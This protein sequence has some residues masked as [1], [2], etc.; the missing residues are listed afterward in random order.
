VGSNAYL[1]EP[2]SWLNDFSDT[3]HEEDPFP[4][5][6]KSSRPAAD[7]TLDFT[8]WDESLTKTDPV[9]TP[10][11]DISPLLFMA[12]AGA[13]TPSAQ[14]YQSNC[15]AAA[16]LPHQHAPVPGHQGSNFLL[17]KDVRGPA[18]HNNG[19]NSSGFLQVPTAP[20]MG[21]RNNVCSPALQPSYN[22]WGVPQQPATSNDNIAI[23][24][25]LT[26]DTLAPSSNYGR[27]HSKQ[28][29]PDC[30]VPPGKMMMDPMCFPGAHDMSMAT[31]FMP[32][33]HQQYGHHQ[34]PYLHQ[35]SCERS[36][37]S[38]MSD[39]A[40]VPEVN[41]GGAQ[42]SHSSGSE[43]RSIPQQQQQQLLHCGSIPRSSTPFQPVANASATAAGVKRKASCAALN[44]PA[45]QPSCSGQT[46]MQLV[47]SASMG[48]LQHAYSG[49]PTPTG[50]SPLGHAS[51]QATAT[52]F[53]QE[54]VA[55]E[56]Q[57]G[58]QQQQQPAQAQQ[59]SAGAAAG[60][61][62]LRTR[63]EA[64][65]RYRQKKANR[66]YTKKIR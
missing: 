43:G 58:P 55:E 22:S 36:Q 2:I 21:H 66:M 1:F 52:R 31:M 44:S 25:S 8:T 33:Y 54:P 6:A 18:T 61:V 51:G 39:T 17:T 35:Q 46:G 47:P 13:P 16:P 65:E 10:D 53:K 57:Q 63:A 26:A 60:A 14:G 42:P 45:L 27:A 50:P 19:S 4:T 15:G 5:T 64:L 29:F 56:Q 48:S 30:M 37:S 49:L 11:I 7:I 62:A 24:A 38:C 34:H 59:P 3:P 20:S 40:V 23:S 41:L 28:Q 32:P 12:S 9:E